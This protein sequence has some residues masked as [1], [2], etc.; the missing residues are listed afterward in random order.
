MKQRSFCATAD[1]SKIM[2]VVIAVAR[3]CRPRLVEAPIGLESP[4]L[5]HTKLAGT[6]LKSSPLGGRARSQEQAQNGAH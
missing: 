5:V 6:L 3:D 1:G 2:W 4:M